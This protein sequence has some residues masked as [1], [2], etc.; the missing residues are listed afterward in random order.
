V[1]TDNLFHEYAVRF[2]RGV[3]KLL[4][5]GEEKFIAKSLVLKRA[6]KRPDLFLINKSGKRVILIETQGYSDDWL[7]HRMIATMSL[8][9][10]QQRFRGRMEAAV[11]FLNESQLRAAEKFHRQFR[12]ISSLHFAPRIIVLQRLKVEEL[13]KTNDILLVPLYPLCDITPAEIKRR[14]EGWAKEVRNARHLPKEA[15]DNLLALLGAAITHRIKKIK[16]DEVTEL[17]GGMNMLDTP[18]GKEIYRKGAL[19]GEKKGLQRGLQQGVRKGLS[20]EAQH[21]LIKLAAEK[22]GKMPVE[23]KKRV[24]AITSTQ[25]L[26]RLA[27]ALLKIQNLEEF[28]KMLDRS[29]G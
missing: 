23:L 15:R 6:E 20:Q 21:V 5:T 11:I 13:Q 3:G 27:V 29:Q 28:R 7:Y 16:A 26:E 12:G 1:A 2:P 9:C 10:L 24:G 22:F 18:L 4:G 8:F 14:A 17:L 19:S 25:E